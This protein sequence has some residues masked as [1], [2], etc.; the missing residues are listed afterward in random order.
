MMYGERE[1]DAE[2]LRR[3]AVRRRQVD[4]AL[5]RLDLELASL[6]DKA[7]WNAR[8]GRMWERANM[9]LGLP[10]AVLAAVAGVGAF[11]EFFS[12]IAVGVVALTSAALTATIAFFR[13]DE[14]RRAF[15]AKAAGYEELAD[16]VDMYITVDA[17][18]PYQRMSATYFLADVHDRKR[19]VVKGD[20]CPDRW[21]KGGVAHAGD[22]YSWLLEPDAAPDEG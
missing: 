4:A 18:D 8:R 10:A 6:R 15:K 11:S 22:D 5:D 16:D 12:D 21:V 2:E 3:R 20:P 7:A 19:V 1:P 9:G 13:P 17:W 14:Q